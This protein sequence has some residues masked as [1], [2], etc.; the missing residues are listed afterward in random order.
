V[1]QWATA[2]WDASGAVRRDAQWGVPPG[3]PDADAEKSAAQAPAARER[4]VAGPKQKRHLRPRLKLA[5]AAPCKPAAAR[6][7]ARSC[8]V[9]AAKAALA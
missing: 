1:C 9:K 4:A 3:L 6:F 8:A 5:A 7:G 2:G